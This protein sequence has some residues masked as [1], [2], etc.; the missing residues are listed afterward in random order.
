MRSPI[1]QDFAGAPLERDHTEL[2]GA[3]VVVRA[4]LTDDAGVGN[5]ERQ[6]LRAG[7]GGD[8]AREAVVDDRPDH[9]QR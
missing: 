4:W 9:R 6:C 7:V 8:P 1:F 3:G 5:V 2:V